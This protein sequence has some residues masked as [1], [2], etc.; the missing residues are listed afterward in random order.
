[1]FWPD[2]TFPPINLWTVWPSKEMLQLEKLYD[3]QYGD[4]L[5]ECDLCKKAS[6]D[7]DE[8]QFFTEHYKY[9]QKIKTC[10][11]CSEKLRLFLISSQSNP[12]GT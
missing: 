11:A 12:E 8:L 7:L 2:L 6:K 10:P 9:C 4:Q 3:P 1:M 5:P